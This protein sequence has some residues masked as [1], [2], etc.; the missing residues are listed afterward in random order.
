MK[1][2]SKKMDA[3]RKTGKK[4]LAKELAKEFKLGEGDLVN[5]LESFIHTSGKP[6]L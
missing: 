4:S 2:L 3:G 5:F 1:G 6:I